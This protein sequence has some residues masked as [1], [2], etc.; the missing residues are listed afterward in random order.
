MSV[1]WHHLRKDGL[2]EWDHAMKGLAEGLGCVGDSDLARGAAALIAHPAAQAE[3]LASI[4]VDEILG[5]PRSGRDGSKERRH[6]GGGRG[7]RSK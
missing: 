5:G 3:A 4:A 2:T 1:P 7:S 6:P